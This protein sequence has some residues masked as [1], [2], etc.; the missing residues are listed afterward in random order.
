MV[1]CGAL[2]FRVKPEILQEVGKLIT[3]LPAGFKPHKGIKRVYDNR[4][5]SIETEQVS[6]NSCTI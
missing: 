1:P 5:E 6:Y 3:T 2:W 4:L